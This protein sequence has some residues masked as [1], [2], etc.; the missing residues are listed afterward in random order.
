M[1]FV[2]AA[3]LSI[4][5]LGEPA[6]A[7]GQTPGPLTYP[8]IIT[9]LQTKFPN[10]VFKTKAQLMSFVVG[11]IKRR[12]V[13][14]PLT[15]D[16]E[17]DLRQAG[18]ADDMIAVIRANSP[19]VPVEMIDLGELRNRAVDLVTPEYT[20]E[21]VKARTTGE[22][23]LA[24]EIDENGR[25]ANVT[26]LTVLPNGLTER[27]MDAARRTTFR[28]AMR[29][30]RPARGSGT[31]TYNFKLNLVDVSAA[32]AS[33]NAFRDR[34]ECGRAIAE[35]G[36]ILDVDQKNAKAL[37]G[38]GTCHL[39]EARYDQAAA[40]LSNAAAGDRQD[41]NI[42]FFLALALD[43]KGDVMAAAANYE[44][45]LKLRP[46]LDGQP[47]FQ[48]LYIDR[49][50]MT[51]EQARAA[52]NSIVSACGQAYRGAAP[53]IATML[54]HKRAIAYRMKGDL[55]RAIKELEE[56]RRSSPG[57]SAVKT[58]LQIAYNAR[59][60]ESFNKKDYQDAFDD[61]SLAI[62][63]DPAAPTPYINRCVIYLHAWKRYREAIEDCSEA[64]RIGT[65]SS[66]AYHY[67][68]YAHEMSNSRAEAIADYKKAL[69]LDPR[70]DAARNNLARVESSR[71]S[72]RY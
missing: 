24:L 16:R 2:L 22:V 68:G 47:T 25:V 42:L 33:G 35:Y 61:L 67:R 4:A 40:D 5:A 64:I 19:P 58:Q 56:I 48:C 43:Y 34:R 21:A 8:E 12:K 6:A 55:D 32:L 57:F 71:P 1:V 30:G 54:Y 38:R 72:M 59:G 37:F 44:K 65:R 53:E 7:S 39:M 10:P 27:A 36:R 13:D 49:R 29:D 60:L 28:P 23:K 69:E 20:P 52:A 11:Q 26:R 17:E 50:Q 70:N 15:R 31:I 66:M 41:S 9:A 63:A 18:A 45:A 3:W 62:N 51:A 46:E 14:K